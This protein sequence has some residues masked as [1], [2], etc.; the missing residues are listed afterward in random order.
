M[1]EFA[2]ALRAGTGANV[3]AIGG[4]GDGVAVLRGR[5]ERGG[6]LDEA[7]G[8]TSDIESKLKTQTSFGSVRQRQN[9]VMSIRDVYV[10]SLELVTVLL[11]SQWS[12]SECYIGEKGL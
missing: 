11:K 8:E 6:R 3:D 7:K 1:N 12:H 4:G 10:V 9:G 5:R 2:G